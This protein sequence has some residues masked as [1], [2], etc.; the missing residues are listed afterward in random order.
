[1][2]TAPA[3]Q[4]PE[5]LENGLLLQQN[6]DLVQENERL[7]Q[8]NVKAQ[9]RFDR[10][11][12]HVDALERRLAAQ[13]QTSRE[14]RAGMR[15]RIDGQADV[16]RVETVISAPQSPARIL[17]H[18]SPVPPFISAERTPRTRASITIPPGTPRHL[19][20]H[21]YFSHL[22]HSIHIYLQPDNLLLMPSKTHR[23]K[24][25]EYCR[26]FYNAFVWVLTSQSTSQ[27]SYP[28]LCSVQRK[29]STLALLRWTVG[30]FMNS[31]NICLLHARH[32]E[33]NANRSGTRP[34]N[35][36]T[37]AAGI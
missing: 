6:I 35:P 8:E 18:G 16:P 30:K 19:L 13:E 10:M 36:L 14:E 1:M 5:G 15:Q 11:E 34:R 17:R 33:V 27:Y 20:P 28:G 21:L 31:R 25:L 26:S 29:E 22:Y 37:P 3:F 2:E 9:R 7:R 23:N 32:Q 4:L 12:R 24:P